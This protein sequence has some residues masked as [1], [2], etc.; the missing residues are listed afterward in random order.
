MTKP[1]LLIEGLTVQTV[2]GARTLVS[3]VSFA[4]PRG[5]IVGLVGESGS[6]KS[7]T[8]LSV[9]RLLPPK[10]VRTAAGRIVFDGQDLLALADEPMRALRGK[11]IAYVPQEPMS[12]LNPTVRIGRQLVRV[13]QVHE[14]LGQAAARARAAE[15]LQ[16]MHMRDPERILDA[17]PFQLSGGQRQ[18]V[19]L[20]NAFLCKPDL[21][22]ADE[23]TTALDVTVQAQVL[24]TLRERAEQVGASVLL[25]THNMGVVWSLCSHTVVMR[26]G[27]VVEQGETRA[28]FAA[29]QAAY[30]RALLDAL[31]ER[32]T[33][34]QA[35]KVAG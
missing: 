5:A 2:G 14:G 28:L 3:D 27:R 26:Q 15:T 35:I 21:L 29:P 25:V 1:L 24:A 19:L 13:L 16:Q 20:A 22:I 7:V 31:P 33:P 23:P 30:T 34:R 11:R 9:L 8:S 18:R 32:A 6:G 17:Y 12:A 10:Q 4:V